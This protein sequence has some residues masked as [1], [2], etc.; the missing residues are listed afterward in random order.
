[1][2]SLTKANIIKQKQTHRYKEQ[3]SGYQWG[4]SGGEGQDRSRGLSGI[5][6]YV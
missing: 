1:M 4:E 3:T 2:L 5:N 6:C